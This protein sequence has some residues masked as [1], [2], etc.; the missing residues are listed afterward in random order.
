MNNLS[1][2]TKNKINDRINFIISSNLSIYSKSEKKNMKSFYK[3]K[4]QDFKTIKDD[5]YYNEN[6]STLSSTNVSTVKK[7]EKNKNNL[8][9]SFGN[10]YHSIRLSGKTLEKIKSEATIEKKIFYGKY[11]LTSNYNKNKILKELENKI[12]NIKLNNENKNIENNNNDLYLNNNK[13]IGNKIGENFDYIFLI[14]L[15]SYY[16]KIIQI[17]NFNYTN[18]KL[19]LISNY[20]GLFINKILEKSDNY[21]NNNFIGKIFENDENINK[22]LNYE[23]CL[24]LLSLFINEF[25]IFSNNELKD[26]INCFY[27]CHSNFLS[28]ISLIIKKTESEIK[29]I[30]KESFLKLKNV[31]EKNDNFKDNIKF[32]NEFNIINKIIKN[33]FMSILIKLSYINNNITEK[34][35]KIFY[36][37]KNSK[38]IDLLNN[39]IKENSFVLDKVDKIYNQNK[40]ND[41][42][43]IKS[44]FYDNDNNNELIEK[45]DNLNSTEKLY[46]KDK[47]LNLTLNDLDNLNNN[48]TTNYLIEDNNDEDEDVPKIKPK[49]PFLPPK[50]KNDK[51][52]YTLVLDLDET[53]VHYCEDENDEENAYVKV[54]RNCEEFINTLSQYCEIIIFTASTKYYADIVI[55]GLKECNENINGRLYRQHTDIINGFNVKDLSKIGRDLSKTI[56]I[57]NIE[58]NYQLQ[59]TNGLNIIDFEGEEDDNELE[60]L[61]DDLLKLVTQKGLDVRNELNSIRKAMLN[62]YSNC[63]K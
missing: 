59:P 28:I 37:S 19:L 23:F 6:T 5:F 11:S 57:D 45:L 44:N 50:S 4:N 32:F 63:L 21:D 47:D 2:L 56:I 35:Q 9:E 39:Y 26:L 1:N 16:N 17:L 43:Y 58:E 14:E 62:R 7:N 18:D 36:F 38:Y 30:N 27:Y 48:Q 20:S 60:Y 10:L 55:D 33:L 3:S 31:I 41:F 49:P 51:R 12:K 42:N 25:K 24:Y 40:S 34:I 46:K 53:L 29:N 54:R 52:E 8:R 13:I 15:N 22:F 61:K